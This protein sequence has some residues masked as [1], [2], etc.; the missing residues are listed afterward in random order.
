[1]KKNISNSHVVP[2]PRPRYVSKVPTTTFGD[3]VMNLQAI[4][5]DEGDPA[6]S[7]LC[8]VC[9]LRIYLGRTLSIRWSGQLFGCFRIQQK[10]L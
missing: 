9:A 1:M 8:P 7:L 2:R 4:P 5:P 10:C 6:L 3:Q